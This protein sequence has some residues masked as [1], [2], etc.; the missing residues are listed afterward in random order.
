MSDHRTDETPAKAWGGWSRGW[1]KFGHVDEIADL[2]RVDRDGA[3]LSLGQAATQ[4]ARKQLIATHRR[5][6]DDLVAAERKARGLSS[7]TT[8]QVLAA[9]RSG[10][11]K[12]GR[13]A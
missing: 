4:A 13:H 5:E 6:Y 2:D 7:K 3:M 1:F 10:S 12:R 9:H 8:T 11:Q